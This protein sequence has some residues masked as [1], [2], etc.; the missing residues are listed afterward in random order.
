[1]TINDIDGDSP[2]GTKLGELLQ[3]HG[4]GVTPRG[5][6]YRGPRRDS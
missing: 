6:A 3:Q 1:M 2:A 5:L 4:F